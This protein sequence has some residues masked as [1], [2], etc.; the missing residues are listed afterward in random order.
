MKQYLLAIALMLALGANAQGFLKKGDDCFS[1]KDYVCAYDNYMLGYEAKEVSLKYA[2]YM[3]IGFCLNDFKKYNDAKKW[4]WLSIYEKPNVDA[5][6]ELASSHYNV[7]TYDSAAF[8]YYSKA[9]ALETVDANKKKLAYLGAN[10]FYFAK[11]YTNAQE[12]YNISLKYDSLNVNTNWFAG[13][14]AYQLKQYTASE[15]YY[16]RAINQSKDPIEK[17]SI[18]QSYA[19]IFYAQSKYE[20]ALEYYRKSLLNN[21]RHLN[22][23]LY[24]YD[25]FNALMQYDSAIT[26]MSKYMALLKSNTTIDSIQIANAN[27]LIINSKLF[28]KDTVGAIPYLNELIKYN[29]KSDQIKT[30]I[31]NVL[32]YRNDYKSLETI[33]PN[34]IKYLNAA[35]KLSEVAIL[36]TELARMY[37]NTKQSTKA[38]AL[39]KST[40]LAAPNS[41]MPLEKF[42]VAKMN[43][44]NYKEALDTIKSRQKY[45]T[46][47]EKAFILNYQG[48]IHLLQKDTTAATSIFNTALSVDYNNFLSRYNVGYMLLLKKDT[49]RAMQTWSIIEDQ[50][51]L[52]IN[53]TPTVQPLFQ[54]YARY[55]YNTGKFS[56]AIKHAAKA[57][58]YDSTKGVVNFIYG[59][60]NVSEKKY[61]T[62]NYY[63]NKT[64]KLYQSKK[65]TL[66]L[67]YRWLALS[68]MTNTNGTEKLVVD[69]F[70][71]AV[72]ASPKDSA[73]YND[74]ANYHFKRKNYVAALEQFTKFLNLVSSKTN[75]LSGYYNRSICK[76]YSNDKEGAKADLLKC[77]EMDP[78]NAEVKK[79]KDLLDKAGG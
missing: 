27:R 26:Y 59:T 44:K 76:Y 34:Y 46:T 21:P 71:K 3:R 9:F 70:I 33:L 47:T 11:K 23:Y 77:I 56:S 45:L 19:E 12:A 10:A 24:A 58:Q 7:G 68:E 79:L 13:L 78:N 39:Y 62:G 67:V 43:E 52:P 69:Y 35:G 1:K 28:K 37:E 49:L 66:A 74:F 54:L 31:Y 48:Q 51:F 2:L 36:Q 14:N 38:M 55:Y 4:L 18:Y 57:L 29:I 32:V 72:E 50:S 40:M 5:Y 41:R 42:I 30:Q 17:G 73:I 20:A 6:W 16:T 8:Y 63:L 65:D 53:A 61:F 25:A 75:L 60:A 22:S 15:Q 64:A